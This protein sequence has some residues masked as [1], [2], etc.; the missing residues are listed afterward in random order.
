VHLL[1]AM[2][3]DSGIVVAQ[4]EVGDKTNEIT[5]FQPLLDTIGL[6][7]VVVTADAMHTQRAHASYL[8]EQRSADY[9]LI[10]KA[11]QPHL[12]TQLDTL[13]WD[14]IPLY[15]TE[16]RGHGRAE[17][18]TIR[19]QPA[20][21]NIDFPHVAQVF[22]IER[23]VTDTTTGETTAIAVL[24]ITSLHA[25]RANA[26]QIATHVRQ[27]WTFAETV[28]GWLADAHESRGLVAGFAGV[29]PS[30]APRPLTL[31]S[32]TAVRPPRSPTGNK[33]GGTPDFPP[34]SPISDSKNPNPASSRQ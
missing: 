3:H 33:S 18:C 11:N 6:T 7:G 29:L 16:N 21:D 27:H 10:V 23:Y 19:V 22:L 24:G 5:C 25:A 30:S 32:I 9:I 14:D 26:P 12:F 31:P 17:R 8:V 13:N 4:Q 34:Y 20:P 15:T 28:G 2:T 1:A